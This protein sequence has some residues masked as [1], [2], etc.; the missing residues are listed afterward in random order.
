[1]NRTR[2]DTE[3]GRR[4][5]RLL[6]EARSTQRRLAR[7]LGVP[8]STLNQMITGRMPPWPNLEEHARRA[9]G[10]TAPTEKV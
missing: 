1:V 8:Y 6:V 4:V 2:F 10:L 7:L 5:T 9:L 3:T